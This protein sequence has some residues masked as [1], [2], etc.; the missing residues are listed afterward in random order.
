MRGCLHIASNHARPLFAH[1]DWTPPDGCAIMAPMKLKLR[2]IRQ[3]RR[4]TI[5]QLVAMTGLSRGFLS[6]IETGKR[7]PSV[8]S[9]NVLADA[10]KLTVVDLIDAGGDGPAVARAVEIMRRLPLED[11]QAVVLMAEALLQRRET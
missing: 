5:D 8:T 7:E 4:L 11:Q 1:V 3:A 2:E 9:L 6:Q 10:L